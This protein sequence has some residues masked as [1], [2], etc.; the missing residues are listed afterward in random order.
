MGLFGL[1]KK[2]ITEDIN[3]LELTPRANHGHELSDDGMVWVLV[4]RFDTPFFNKL[5]PKGKSPYIKANLDEFGSAAWL[6]LDGNRKVLE[7]GTELREQFGEGIEPVYERLTQ[8]LT[9]LYQNKFIN[10]IEL[11]RKK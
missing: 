2:K 4:P 10:F 6:L 5:L 1:G 8:F 7:I 9:T 3:Y 11:E